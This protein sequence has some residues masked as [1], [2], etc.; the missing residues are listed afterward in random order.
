VLVSTYTVLCVG[1]PLAGQWKV[2][3]E[4]TFEAAE[5]PKLTFSTE[6]TDTAI[7][8][9]VR[10]RYHVENFVMFGFATWVAVC[11]RQFMGSTE[12]NK[13]IMRALLQRDVAA[14]M[15]VL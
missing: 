2:V 1:G 13:A 15:G 7:E 12:R 3:N 4:R 8:P 6:D 5:P 14:Q 10:H 9:F 11:E